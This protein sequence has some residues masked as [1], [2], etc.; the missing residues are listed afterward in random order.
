MLKK[1]KK[2]IKDGLTGGWALTLADYCL[3]G[4]L[5]GDETAEL[6]QQVFQVDFHWLNIPTDT[7][8]KNSQ[9]L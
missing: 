8:N 6:L 4:G 3:L 7:K 9:V 1:R 5:G 2:T